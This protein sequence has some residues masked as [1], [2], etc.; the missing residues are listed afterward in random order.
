[1]NAQSE[2]WEGFFRGPWGQWQTEGFKQENTQA[3]AALLVEALGLKAGEKVLD[4]A[5]GTGRHAV[6]LAARGIEVTGIDFNETALRAARRKATARGVEV[7]FVRQDMRCLGYR[8]QFDA[9]YCFWTSF[10]YFEDESHD[11]VVARR[12][13]EAL[14]PGGRFLLEGMATE[15]LLPI[16][17]P[18]RTEWLDAA[19]TRQVQQETHFDCETGR[20]EEDWTFIE[21]GRRQ[22]CHSSLR[23]YSYR[24]LC[25]LLREAGFESF[26]GYDTQTGQ[27]FGLG[28]SRLSLVAS[29]G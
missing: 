2:W 26:T 13:A 27:A 4:V 25:D 3:E 17:E 10:G 1:M 14:K 5:C 15:T 29:L 28:A 19:R 21:N 22:S 12:I 6:E 23:L 16:F 7:D 8:E 11:F 20:V 9:A 24:E 18:R